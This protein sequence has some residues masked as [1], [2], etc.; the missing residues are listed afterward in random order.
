MSKVILE[1]GRFPLKKALAEAL[2][3]SVEGDLPIV[4]ELLFVSEKAIR[5]LNAR[6]RGVDKVTDVLSFPAGNYDPH[7]PLLSAE[8]AD[9]VEPVMGKKKG[10]WVQKSARLYLGSVVICKKRAAEQAEEYGHSYERELCYLAVHGFL[11]CLGYDHETEEQKRPM[12]AREEEIMAKL[13][14]EREV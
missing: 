11:H 10:E 9:C 4:L 5:S 13:G 7:R 2:S 6:E 14:L 3:G 8:H 12:R 1:G